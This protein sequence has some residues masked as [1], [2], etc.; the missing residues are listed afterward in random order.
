VSFGVAGANPAVIKE[1]ATP[2]PVGG[3]KKQSFAFLADH[4]VSPGE[5]M[6][7]LMKFQVNS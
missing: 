5:V 2:F 3:S 6:K 1:V 7:E 4:G